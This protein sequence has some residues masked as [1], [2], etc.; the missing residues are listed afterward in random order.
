MPYKI[1]TAPLA[2]HYIAV[3]KDPESGKTLHHFTLN[4]TAH[5]MLI[6][7]RDG[8]TVEQTALH[9]AEEYGIPYERTLK[10]VQGF[11]MKIKPYLFQ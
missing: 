11:Y 7:L 8:N 4:A 1:E 2:G 6:L 9:L 10:D 3:I 5:E